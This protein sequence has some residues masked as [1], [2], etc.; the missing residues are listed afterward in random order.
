V[1]A[2][3]YLTIPFGI[4]SLLNRAPLEA[5][6]GPETPRLRWSASGDAIEFSDGRTFLLA[7]EIAAFLEGFASRRALMHFG[8]VLHFLYLLRFAH[9]PIT[10]LPAFPGVAGDDQRHELSELARAWQQGRVPRNA[11]VFCAHLCRAVPGLASS[12]GVEEVLF[13]LRLPHTYPTQD[14]NGSE[15]PPLNPAEFEAQLARALGGISFPA[16]VHWFRHGEPPL[17]NAA[18]QLAQELLVRPPRTLEGVLADLARHQRLSGSAPFVAQLLSALS[19]PRRRLAQRELPLGGYSDVTTRGQP[20]QILPVQLALEEWEFV[21]RH[22]EHELLYFHREEPHS[23]L[24]EELVLLLD[25][26]VRTWGVVR[27]VLAAAVFALGQL[28][29]RRRLTLLLAT[30]GNGGVLVDPVRGRVHPGGPEMD[31]SSL[32]DFLSASDL[33]P[34]PALALEQVLTTPGPAGVDTSPTRQRGDVLRDVVLLTQPRNLWESDVLA[35]A[36]RTGSATRLFALAVDGQGVSELSEIRHGSPVSL[37]RFHVDLTAQPPALPDRPSTPAGQPQRLWKGEIEPVPFPFCFGAATGQGGTEFFAFDAEGTW[38]LQVG[39]RGLLQATRTDGESTEVLPRGFFHEQPIHRVHALLG[40]KGGFVVCASVPESILFV[41]YDFR[42]RTVRI[43]PFAVNNRHAP[44]AWRYLR[45]QHA[46]VAIGPGERHGVQ[47]YKGNEVTDGLDSVPGLEWDMASGCALS[48]GASKPTAPTFLLPYQESSEPSGSGGSWRRPI[49]RFVLAEN[50]LELDGVLPAWNRFVPLSDGKPTLLNQDLPGHGGADCQGDTLAVSLR[51]RTDKRESLYLFQG[52]DG[53]LLSALHVQENRDFTLS[54][55][56]RW[57]AL[58]KGPGQIEIRST[59]DPAPPRCVTL[60]GRY[61]HDVVVELGESWLSLRI[62]KTIHLAR[63][64]GP[65]LELSQGRGDWRSFLRNALGNRAA[66][67][68]LARPDRVPGFLNYDR[69]RFRAAAW[70][71]LVAVVDLFGEV[72]LFE[73]TGDLVC[74]FFAFRHHLAAW[75]PDGTCLG[76]EGVL[77]QN[78]AGCPDPAERIG[79][80]LQA[81][82]ERGEGTIT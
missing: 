80:A 51:S 68:T 78:R 77:G 50:A 36:R 45:R 46:V 81:A 73:H 15:D 6:S 58:Q 2:A 48:A 74:A 54:S 12:P 29:S 1:N 47:L 65:R 31:D 64:D 19:L 35:A 59:R 26:G 53:V 38:L 70:A 79:R 75:M 10:P 49:L 69:E 18:E 8:H 55:D 20:E 9:T 13:Y 82:W 67:T 37:L 5:S 52:P 4:G 7:V 17:D 72:F 32:G 40:V 76:A 27:L 71:N 39:A 30:S 24:N 23:P 44:R 56:G 43:H 28:A 62:D 22:A 57:L 21:R 25:Q 42:E 11:G 63:W 34:H 41:H 60:A 61:H 33:S 16:R 14:R 66:W 3:H